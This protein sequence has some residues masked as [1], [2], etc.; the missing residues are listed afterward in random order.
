MCD[1]H[2]IKLETIVSEAFYEDLEYLPEYIIKDIIR[3]YTR[4]W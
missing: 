4:K 2:Q 1:E 3:R